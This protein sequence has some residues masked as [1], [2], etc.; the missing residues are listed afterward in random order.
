MSDALISAIL[1]QQMQQPVQAPQPSIGDSIM[2]GVANSFAQLPSYN[3]DAGSFSNIANSFLRGVGQGT[4]SNLMQKQQ[5][6]AREA[7]AQ[8]TQGLMDTIL[9]Y[10]KRKS[11]QQMELKRAEHYGDT[12]S[13]KNQGYEVT[14]EFTPNGWSPLGQSAIPRSGSSGG[15]WGQ[16]GA[17]ISPQAPTGVMQP[18]GQMPRQATPNPVAL[19]PQGQLQPQPQQI[20]PEESGRLA[21]AVTYD[22]QIR[23]KMQEIQ[24]ATGAPP[25]EAYKIAVKGAS[26]SANRSSA[27]DDKEFL[28]STRNTVD[29]L[30]S[31]DMSLD[32]VQKGIDEAGVTGS[33]LGA[34]MLRTGGYLASVVSDDQAKKYEAEKNITFAYVNYLKQ[35]Q[36][37]L[38]GATS[39]REFQAL[40][41]QAPSPELS[42]EENMRRVSAARAWVKNRINMESA[43]LELGKR[44]PRGEIDDLRTDYIREVKGVTRKDEN[45]N[46]VPTQLFSE[47]L[48][49]GGDSSQNTQS[50]QV[51]SP[52]GQQQ[53][54]V[55]QQQAQEAATISINLDSGRTVSPEEVSNNLVPAKLAEAV[56]LQESNGDINAVSPA[57]AQGA[58]QVMPATGKEKH[59]ELV[60]K[61]LI[62]KPYDPFDAEQNKLI[63]VSF[64]GDRI[65]EFND[66]EL[67]LAAYNSGGGT[68]RKALRKAQEQGKPATFESIAELLPEETRNYVPSVLSKMTTNSESLSTSQ[69]QQPQAQQPS[70]LQRAGN[71]AQ[72]L[73]LQAMD[74]LSLGF[75]DEAAAGLMNIGDD[76]G[77]S[78]TLKNLRNSRESFEKDNPKMALAADIGG[79][80]APAVATGG[81]S[82]GV[83]A[84]RALM[85]NGAKS[86]MKRVGKGAATSAGY[87]AL[88]A[89]GSGEG[90]FTRRTQDA[91]KGGVGSAVIGGSIP[92]VN[93]V[94]KGVTKKISVGAIEAAN[95]AKK[96]AGRK[97]KIGATTKLTPSQ[98]AKNEIIESL[99]SSATPKQVKTALQDLEYSKRQGVPL[100][101]ADTVPSVQN[102]ARTLSNLSSASGKAKEKIGERAG[103]SVERQQDFIT[104]QAKRKG[105]SDRASGVI[106]DI[107]NNLSKSN[108]KLSSVGSKVYKKATEGKVYKSEEV[109][110]LVESPSIKEAMKKARSEMKETLSV[111]NVV[112][113][114]AM[115]EINKKAAA[116]VQSM[117][118]G[119]KKSQAFESQKAK[120]T[121][122]YMNS[123][124]KVL[125]GAKQWLEKSIRDMNKIG[126]TRSSALKS[127]YRKRL[128]KIKNV[129]YKENPAYKK[130]D[131]QYGEAYRNMISKFDTKQVKFI[132]NLKDGNHEKVADKLINGHY[133]PKNIKEIKSVFGNQYKKV[134]DFV[135]TGIENKLMSKRGNLNVDLYNEVFKKG[136]SRRALQEALGET[137]FKKL[138]K[139][140]EAESKVSRGNR[141]L[142]MGSTTASHL[143][144]GAKE[145]IEVAKDAAETGLALKMGNPIWATRSAISGVLKG[146]DLLTKRGD[147]NKAKIDYYLDTDKGIELLRDAI[148]GL[149][150]AKKRAAKTYIRERETAKSLG[151]FIGSR[152]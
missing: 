123:S 142:G 14:Q 73:G 127:D 2:G 7:E 133:S 52:R 21:G 53:Q 114:S 61:G 100:G 135:Y 131:E 58:M 59:K 40:L 54:P 89:F 32:T 42:K 77:Y 38:K 81:G 120:L 19:P 102:N 82:L 69:Q 109:K 130:A 45:G 71:Y 4:A 57:G 3:P 145:G 122:E 63:G 93:R 43:S 28:D 99:N 80:L 72:G 110:K 35:A 65:Q 79:S 8:R 152:D 149:P 104:R 132:R 112:P 86:L 76:E 116:K 12:R 97:I 31:L 125:H 11:A 39:D 25:E 50:P 143:Q 62:Q 13:F 5:A 124:A 64:L 22:E 137:K 107:E 92:V 10:E 84:G 26:N 106:E 41:S 105:L 46:I 115:K 37:S 83:S 24:R 113:K 6:Q 148:K 23:Q 147:I 121:E 95:K 1:K 151:K 150:Q 48:K 103:S 74:G 128:E 94:G 68:V 140:F 136:S 47:W 51:A 67:G 36:E 17:A 144:E 141:A 91:I 134:E 119:A 27:N 9:E 60:Q 90:D 56:I 108:K 78:Q 33:S 75:F 96:A 34:R 101:I 129:L 88:S 126:D 98:R 66:V 16:V 138:E 118:E 146:K 111:E 70:T 117:K 18:R 15:K 87:G 20:Q 30:T 85:K 29:V 55:P 139:Y 49:G 44:Y